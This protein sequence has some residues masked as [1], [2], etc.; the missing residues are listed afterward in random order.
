[1]KFKHHVDLSKIIDL[2]SVAKF[3]KNT[4]MEQL[5]ITYTELGIN[6][7]SA[8]M[9]ITDKVRQPA[10]LLHGGASVAF[11]ESLGSLGSALLVDYKKFHV[12]CIEISANHIRG[13]KDG[14]VF[15]KATIIHMGK[16]THVWVVEITDEEEN[17]ISS[18]RLTMMI[19]PMQ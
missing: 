19:I 3:N 9:E 18:A 1:M 8:K 7:L 5:G 2:E 13:K 10:G 14:T 4:L 16:T 17:I 15:G 12:S 11:A 6:S